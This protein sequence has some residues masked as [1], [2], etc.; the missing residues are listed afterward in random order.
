[1]PNSEESVSL[2]RP[3]AALGGELAEELVLKS[4]REGDE[5]VGHR[6]GLQ[7]C[8]IEIFSTLVPKL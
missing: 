8:G 3:F 4:A 5:A 6:V 1:M 2:R 7:G